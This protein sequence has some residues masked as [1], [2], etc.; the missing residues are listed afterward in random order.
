MGAGS[1]MVSDT[2]ASPSSAAIAAYVRLPTPIHAPG[3]PGPAPV[4]QT[5]ERGDNP[6]ERGDGNDRQIVPERRGPVEALR[7]YALEG[8]AH[9]DVMR[10]FGDAMRHRKKPRER[11]HGERGESG[12]RE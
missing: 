2:R 4:S 1:Q 8:L 9:E 5:S 12:E 10:E 3:Q 11:D 6:R 7:G